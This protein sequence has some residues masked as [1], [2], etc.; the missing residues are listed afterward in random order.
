MIIESWRH[1]YERPVWSDSILPYIFHGRRFES[2]DL[3]ALYQ[4]GSAENEAGGLLH[5]KNTDT[6][7]VETSQMTDAAKGTMVV[8]RW[9]DDGNLRNRNMSREEALQQES[10]PLRSIVQTKVDRQVN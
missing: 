5:S 7:L 1:R 6:L 8:F 3:G 2:Q 9:S 4:S 10:I